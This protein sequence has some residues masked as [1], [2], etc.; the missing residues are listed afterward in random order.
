MGANCLTQEQPK[1]AAIFKGRALRQIFA[2]PDGYRAIAF[3]AEDPGNLPDEVQDS[4]EVVVRGHTPY[5]PG[6]HCTVYGAW[7][8]SP[9][10]GWQFQS[11]GRFTIKLP[12][13]SSDLQ[14]EYCLMHIVKSSALRLCDAQQIFNTVGLDAID[15]IQRNGYSFGKIKDLARFDW[16]K[17]TDDVRAALALPTLM[18]L[19]IPYGL[20][21][22]E[23]RRICTAYGDHYLDAEADLKRNP[24]GLIG[25]SAS[26]DTCDKIAAGSGLQANDPTRIIAGM[27]A[28]ITS[29]CQMTG[30][31]YMPVS[32]A[33]G[34]IHATCRLLNHQPWQ[35]VAADDVCAVLQS[36]DSARLDHIVIRSTADGPQAF[37]RS[38]DNAEQQTSLYISAMLQELPSRKRAEAAEKA[39][40]D[41]CS[42]HSADEPDLSDEQKDA[43]RNALTHRVSVITGGPGTGKTTILHCIIDAYQKMY[44]KMYPYLKDGGRIT[45]MA[46][47]GKAAQRMTS[48]IG[49]PA[50]TIHH[51][52]GIATEDAEVPMAKKNSL[53]GLIIIDEAS[54]LSMMLMRQ[55]MTAVSLA[56]SMLVLVGDENQLPS[57]GPGRV[58]H[59]LISSQAVCVS[60]LTQIYR[61]DGASLIPVNAEKIRDKDSDLTWS[62]DFQFVEASD[63]AEAAGKVCDIYK[64]ESAANGCAET[65]VLCPRRVETTGG[66]RHECASDVLAVRLRN[67]VN[68]IRRGE[69]APTANG[70]EFHTGDRVMQTKNCQTSV[71]GDTGTIMRLITYGGKIPTACSILW[72]GQAEETVVSLADMSTITLAY[73]VSVHKSQGSQYRTVIIPLPSE[74]RSPLYTRRLLY[75]AVTR[76]TEKVIIVGDKRMIRTCVEGHKPERKSLLAARLRRRMQQDDGGQMKGD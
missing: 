2:S 5:F 16:E 20:T 14:A 23:I 27:G 21:S 34:L 18:E 48:A 66:F 60:R 36:K 24:Y 22:A 63:D 33:S 57:V 73:A 15:K 49:M 71:N 28:V 65:A 50:H 43:V 1:A 54:M 19:L 68:P 76:A 74:N 51:T 55:I 52:L 7:C 6:A 75:T 45:L 32:G 13:L 30:N 42:H 3:A 35:P 59:E 10:Y 29:F 39:V 12:G 4:Y 62:D 31:T 47:T 25:D 53:T 38:M 70:T 61:Q 58:L 9:K 26:F 11:D 69:H 40:N 41:V 72:D 67:L 8:D 46:P 37:T 56:D 17:I 44:K 64:E